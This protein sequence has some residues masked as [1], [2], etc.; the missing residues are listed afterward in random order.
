MSK[1]NVKILR[2]DPENGANNAFVTYSVG[3]HKNSTIIE[4]LLQIYERYDST[5]AFNYGCRVK[6]CGLCAVNV[7]G[8]PHY[9]CVTRIEDNMRISPIEKLPLI[10]DLVF[11]RKP[12]YDFLN[13]FSPYVVREKGPETLPEVLIQPPEHSILMSCRECFA[14]T[15]L[16][17]RYDYKDESF[18]G[19]LAFVKLAQLHYDCRDSLDRVSQAIKIGIRKCADC[20][21]CACISGIP[22]N[23]IVIKPFLEISEAGEKEREG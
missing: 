11:D 4:A 17:P 21:R 13:K 1:V 2:Y 8:K 20:G 19:P 22:I 10:K 3:A 5:L 23:K 14:C 16:C 12:F 9:A 18:G 7:D 6:N 15:S